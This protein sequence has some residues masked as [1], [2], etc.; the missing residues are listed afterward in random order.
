[1]TFGLRAHNIDPAEHADRIHR[2]LELVNLLDVI[3]LDIF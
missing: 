3:D 1:M 2:A